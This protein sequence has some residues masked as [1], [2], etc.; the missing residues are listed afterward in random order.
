MELLMKLNDMGE[1]FIL[2][3]E[4]YKIRILNKLGETIAVF[5]FMNTEINI[6]SEDEKEFRYNGFRV[7]GNS[8]VYEK[9]NYFLS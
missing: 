2:N 3:P 1:D 4:N 6:L 7:I 9:I 5:P 8:E